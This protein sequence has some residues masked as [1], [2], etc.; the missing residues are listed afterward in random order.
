MRG[1]TRNKTH[2][3]ENAEICKNEVKRSILLSDFEQFSPL[4][5]ILMVNLFRRNIR[6]SEILIASK[7]VK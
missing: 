3:N 1:K 7:K 4:E 2:K 5:F 6:G